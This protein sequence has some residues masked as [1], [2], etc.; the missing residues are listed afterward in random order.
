MD[1][2]RD[3]RRWRDDWH[4]ADAAHSVGVVRVRN[5]D[6]HPYGVK[7]VAEAG[8]VSAMSAVANAVAMATGRRMAELPMSPP[9]LLDAIDEREGP[10]L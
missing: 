6:D 9:R 5:L 1:R 3:R 7:G 4:L 10:E 2:I 8:M